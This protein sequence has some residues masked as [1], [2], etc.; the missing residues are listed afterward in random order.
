MIET[1]GHIGP[2]WSFISC[3]EP[4]SLETLTMRAASARRSSGSSALVTATGPNT[5]VS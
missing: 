1:I 5:L 4:T 3:T 2:S